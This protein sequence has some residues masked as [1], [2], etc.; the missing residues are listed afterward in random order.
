MVF[1]I[2]GKRNGKKTVSDNTGND[3]AKVTKMFEF[4]TE[5]EPSRATIGSIVRFMWNPGTGTTLCWVQGEV[6]KRVDP[7][8][9]ARKEQWNT[10]RVKIKNL[11]IVEYWGEEYTKKLPKT[12]VVDLSKKQAWALGTEVTLEK[13]EGEEIEVNLDAFPKV[14]ENFDDDPAEVIE[15]KG[16]AGGIPIIEDVSQGNIRNT[17]DKE[18][19][20]NPPE[21]DTSDEESLADDDDLDQVRRLRTL[22]INEW[23]TNEKTQ[24]IMERVQSAVEQNRNSEAERAIGAIGDTINDAHMGMD[25]AFIAGTLATS[26]CVARK[27]S[28]EYAQQ[29][30]EKEA[31]L[32]AFKAKTYLKQALNKAKTL[33]EE[34]FIRVRRWLEKDEETVIITIDFLRK[35]RIEAK[36]SL[37]LTN[38]KINNPGSLG[39]N[40]KWKVPSKNAHPNLKVTMRDSETSENKVNKERA[41]KDSDTAP[42]APAEDSDADEHEASPPNYAQSIKQQRTISKQSH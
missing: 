30:N 5:I 38:D 13:D 24:D 23:L 12:M 35:I 34:D 41:A 42:S 2:L 18:V 10:N 22:C 4:L 8:K 28:S 37:K 29:V 17:E 15:E 9:K 25:Q 7:Y 16:A 1:K 39:A 33:A 11:K 20:E 31:K 27:D 3:V 21:D 36:R 6:E 19:S 14:V 26:A 40:P 32:A